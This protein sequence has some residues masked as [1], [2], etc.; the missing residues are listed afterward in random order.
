M[1]QCT[2]KV[3]CQSFTAKVSKWST[4]WDKVV[5]AENALLDLKIQDKF[6]KEMKHVASFVNR[7]VLLY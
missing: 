4:I 2:A 3:S 7:Q 1:S 6:L 5:F